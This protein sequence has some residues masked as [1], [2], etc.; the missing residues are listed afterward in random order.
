[1][2]FFSRFDTAIWRCHRSGRS[3][4][5][6]IPCRNGGR[7][8]FDLMH[9]VPQWL[10]SDFQA[11]GSK[12]RIFHGTLD[13]IPAG[14]SRF[15]RIFTQM[16]CVLLFLC[17]SPVLILFQEIRDLLWY[18]FMR[19]G[20]ISNNEVWLAHWHGKRYLRPSR[21][22]KY[23]KINSVFISKTEEYFVSC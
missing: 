12:R 17:L 10:S 13:T 15:K 18:R 9:P 7:A 3:P 5:W 11:G 16:P 19:P 1:M 4:P 2:Q 14:Q 21:Y 23:T 6:S 8:G 20:A 22:T